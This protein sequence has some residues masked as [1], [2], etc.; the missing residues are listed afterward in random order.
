MTF[1]KQE[2]TKYPIPYSIHSQ[3]I[4]QAKYL[5][6]NTDDLE[7]NQ[8]CDRIGE[9]SCKK[10]MSNIFTSPTFHVKEEDPE[11]SDYGMPLEQLVELLARKASSAYE[12][13]LISERGQEVISQALKYHIPFDKQNIDFLDLIDQLEDY[14]VLI[15]RADELQVDWDSSYYDP[16]AIEQAIFDSEQQADQEQTNLNND[17]FASIWLARGEV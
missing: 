14:E 11:R 16:M 12:Q 17:Y 3:I 5:G 13:M 6:I 9:E 10:T 15:K 8:I 7:L 1:T 2:V 4:F